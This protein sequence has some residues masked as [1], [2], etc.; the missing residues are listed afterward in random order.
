MVDAARAVG[1]PEG[2]FPRGAEVAEV[3]LFLPAA[4]AAALE[5]AAC[6]RGLT[7]AQ[8]LRRL[9]R[10]FL[11]RGDSPRAARAAGAGGQAQGRVGDAPAAASRPGDA[12]VLVVE[13]DP[14]VRDALRALLAA[15]GHRVAAAGNGREALN[16]LRTHRPPRVILLDLMMPT[17]SGWEFRRQQRQDAAL[18]AIPVVLCSGV[19]DVAAE[20]A[21][22]GA[23]YHLAKPVQPDEL[24]AAV[25]HFCTGAAG[26]GGPDAM[27]G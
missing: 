8:L 22:V 14:R 10:D 11:A 5:Q 27:T 24:V 21:L 12:G 15:R 19:E 25:D 17:M 1:P 13:D 6:S 16:Y 9:V 26:Q 20:A 23:D 18:A 4:D 7:A 2:L 3:T